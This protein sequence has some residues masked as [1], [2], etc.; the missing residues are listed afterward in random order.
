[1][2]RVRI[3]LS[4]GVLSMLQLDE[5]VFMPKGMGTAFV[6]GPAFMVFGSISP[7]DKAHLRLDVD[8]RR[9]AFADFTGAIPRGR[10][11]R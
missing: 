6:I 4:M 1:M 7:A 3:R 8:F 10:M 11:P 9:V 5:A 2:K